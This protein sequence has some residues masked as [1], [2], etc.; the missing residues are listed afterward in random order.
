VPGE[1]GKSPQKH[2]YDE[3]EDKPICADAQDRRVG[4]LEDS[5]DGIRDK[6]TFFVPGGDMINQA[7]KRFPPTVHA[8]SP[9]RRVPNF[10]RG[11]IRWPEASNPSSSIIGTVIAKPMMND[12]MR[13]LKRGEKPASQPAS[14]PARPHVSSV[15][16]LPFHIAALPFD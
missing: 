15:V 1:T 4:V 14:Q 9:I 3:T 12:L 13:G 2:D 6:P 7:R 8:R 11:F 10:S 16:P 5:R